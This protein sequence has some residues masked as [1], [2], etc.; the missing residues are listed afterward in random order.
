MPHLAAKCQ[1]MLGNAKNAKNAKM[2]EKQNQ[3]L[4]NFFLT[5]RW[6]LFY[7]SIYSTPI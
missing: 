3:M 6:D 5:Y 7:I 2:A 1:E 4:A